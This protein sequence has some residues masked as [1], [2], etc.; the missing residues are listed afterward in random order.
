MVGV[1]PLEQK[2]GYE[3]TGS[4]QISKFC[5]ATQFIF[6]ARR[7]FFINYTLLTKFCFYCRRF[8]QLDRL[9]STF[10]IWIHRL[11][12]KMLQGFQSITFILFDWYWFFRSVLACYGGACCQIFGWVT[13]ISIIPKFEVLVLLMDVHYFAHF[14]VSFMVVI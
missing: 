5:I 9:I 2:D 12:S 4:L 7:C 1:V 8:I 3:W 10:H 6:V 11:R 13:R 14:L